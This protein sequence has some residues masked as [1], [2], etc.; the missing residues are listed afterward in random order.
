MTLFGLILLQVCFS[1][2][3]CVVTSTVNT[4]TRLCF[5]VCVTVT[6]QCLYVCY[7]NE[8]RYSLE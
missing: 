8:T 4:D 3:V 2:H 7:F 5:M 6:N 1:E